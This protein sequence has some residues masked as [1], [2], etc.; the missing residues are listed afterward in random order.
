[1]KYESMIACS[2]LQAWILSSLMRFDMMF[3]FLTIHCVIWNHQSKDS[4]IWWE[5]ERGGERNTDIY[6]PWAKHRFR[7]YICY[8]ACQGIVYE[9][10]NLD[11]LAFNIDLKITAELQDSG[12]WVDK[13]ETC[14]CI[15][16]Q[17]SILWICNIIKWASKMCFKDY[18]IFLI[19]NSLFIGPNG[20]CTFSKKTNELSK[21]KTNHVL[22]RNRCNQ[23]EE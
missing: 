21:S 6:L 9:N 23:M 12:W 15:V 7:C 19:Q 10:I 4:F 16:S 8:L 1:M 14:Q 3:F 20:P 2:R 11:V 17:L 18:Y 13:T 22:L 5:R